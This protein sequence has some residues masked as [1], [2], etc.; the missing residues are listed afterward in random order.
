M[1]SV[2]V[3]EVFPFHQLS[4]QINI[5]RIAQKRVELLSVRKVRWFHLPG[6][7]LRARDRRPALAK[8]GFVR[9][10]FEFVEGFEDSE[11]YFLMGFPT[12]VPKGGIHEE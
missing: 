7:L 2:E 12:V 3:V 5:I 8:Q 11:G 9:H 4:I 1:A 10:S 6:Q